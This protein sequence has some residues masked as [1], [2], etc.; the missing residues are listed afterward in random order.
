MDSGAPAPEAGSSSSHRFSGTAA[1]SSSAA[2]LLPRCGVTPDQL[3]GLAY[4][5][6]GL[7]AEAAVPRRGAEDR[8]YE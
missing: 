3:E 2:P 8:L 1:S 4:G 6:D 7:G 5:D